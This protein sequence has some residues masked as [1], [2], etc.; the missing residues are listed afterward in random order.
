[1][2]LTDNPLCIPVRDLN[3]PV[4]DLR[5]TRRVEDIGVEIERTGLKRSLED[6]GDVCEQDIVEEVAELCSKLE[7]ARCSAYSNA[8]LY[9]V[10]LTSVRTIPPSE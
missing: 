8:A 3:Q 9:G 2:D 10:R 5:C 7:P 1:M 4:I 6:I